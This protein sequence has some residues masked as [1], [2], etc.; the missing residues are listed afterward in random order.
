MSNPKKPVI[1]LVPK[2]PVIKL[3]PKNTETKRE[4]TLLAP[5]IDHEQTIDEQRRI[6]EKQQKEISDL[7]KANAE[8]EKFIVE[9][10][11]I[12]DESEK[13]HLETE[14]IL[15]NAFEIRNNQ[16]KRADRALTSSSPQIRNSQFATQ[17][18][19]N[20]GTQTQL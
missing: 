5:S 13:K 12:T 3:V 4:K 8:Q 6:I 9:Q 11:K 15:R 14:Q 16:V 7:K 19:S 17:N 2:K 10:K 20:K 1:K 18:L